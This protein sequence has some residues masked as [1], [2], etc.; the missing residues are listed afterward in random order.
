[1]ILDPK[2]PNRRLDLV[3]V[4]DGITSSSLELTWLGPFFLEP[5]LSRFFFAFKGCILLASIGAL[6]VKSANESRSG[7]ERVP[8]RSALRL[9]FGLS[10]VY[11]YQPTS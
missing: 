9:A 10:T 6:F 4:F 5:F 2:A 1:M 3:P 8:L 7:T 11:L